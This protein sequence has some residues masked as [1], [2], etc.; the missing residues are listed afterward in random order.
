MVLNL[1]EAE[2]TASSPQVAAVIKELQESGLMSAMPFVDAPNGIKK[3]RRNVKLGEAGFRAAYEKYGRTISEYEVQAEG[4]YDFGTE[5]DVDALDVDVYTGNTNRDEQA[6]DAITSIRLDYERSIIKGDSVSSGGREFDGL[7]KRIPTGSSQYINNGGGGLVL[8]KA[9]EAID[10]VDA[11]GGTLTWICNK[12]I[13]RQLTLGLHDLNESGYITRGQDQLGRQITLFCD[14]P[15]IVVDRDSQNADILPF[16]E[17]G[18]TT[19]MYLVSWGPNLCAGLKSTGELIRI[20]DLGELDEAP[21]YRQRITFYSGLYTPNQ[22]AL[23]R[24]GNISAGA[25]SLRA[26]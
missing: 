9:L 15:L 13:R 2:K 17:P 23:A 24:I 1:I 16:S 21:V 3:Y 19:S 14:V 22:R 20:K 12:Q 10:A 8:E 11:P 4:L 7:Q 6:L 5:I 18:N 25:F 26:A